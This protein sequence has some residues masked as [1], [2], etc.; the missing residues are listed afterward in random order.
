V[1]LQTRQPTGWPPWPILLIAG[2]EKS[3]KSYASAAASASD[4][5]NRTL[6]FGIGEDDPDELGALEGARFE[7]VVQDGT[8]RGLINTLTEAVRL[9]NP[10]V[11]PNLLVLDSGTRLWQL[12]SDMAQVEANRRWKNRDANK[13]KPI[14]EDG[15]SIN[16]DLWNIAKQRWQHVL[17]LL[18]EHQGPSIITARL[19]ET[20]VMDGDKPTKDK[21]WKVQAEKGLPF[22]VGAIVEL[23]GRNDAYLTGIRS[24]RWIT[25]N[26]HEPYPK[27]TVDDLWRKLGLAEDAGGRSHTRASGEES[28]AADDAHQAARLALLSEIAAAAEAAGVTREQVAEQWMDEHGGEIRNATDLGALELLRDD[29]QSKAKGQAA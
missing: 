20:T 16:M 3:G 24:L 6:W 25:E 2:V 7:I 17:D 5:V 29:L 11:K 9:D 23:R 15:I 4:L 21:F 14:P 19:E 18:R 1:T 12:L 26:S 13:S 8:Y 27:F 28:M 10:N 22:D